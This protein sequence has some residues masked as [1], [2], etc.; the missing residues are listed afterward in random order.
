MN[1]LF[2]RGYIE[3]SIG[4]SFRAFRVRFL[5]YFL[6]LYFLAWWVHHCDCLIKALQFKIMGGF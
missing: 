4:S 1:F 5:F 3:I 2:I 6:V